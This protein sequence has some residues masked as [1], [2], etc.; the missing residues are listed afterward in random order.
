MNSVQKHVQHVNMFVHDTI[1]N[2]VIG[3]FTCTEYLAKWLN[4]TGIFR[5]FSHASDSVDF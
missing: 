2:G 5:E 4:F 3:Y 1:T